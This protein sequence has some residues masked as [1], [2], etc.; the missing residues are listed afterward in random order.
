MPKNVF[1]R[2][3]AWKYPLAI[4]MLMFLL[5]N[6]AVLMRKRPD[7]AGVAH[8]DHAKLRDFFAHFHHRHEKLAQIETRSRNYDEIFSEINMY[9]FL[10]KNSF[11][12]RCMIYFNHLSMSNPDWMVNPDQGIV[13]NRDAYKSFD[14][15]REQALKDIE[16]KLNDAKEKGDNYVPPSDD[17]IRRKFDEMRETVL[18]DEQTLHDYLAHVRIFDKCFMG[19][20][21]TGSNKDDIAFVKKQR[22]F[23]KKSVVYLKSTADQVSGKL[24][25][26]ELDCND[27]ESKIFPW[28]TN[29]YPV[30]TRWN[31]RLTFFPGMSGRLPQKRGCFLSEYKSRLN[32]RGIVMT[33]KDDHVSD[34]SRFLRLLR[35]LGNQYPIQVVYHL[36]L[37]E[38]SRANLVRAARDY[39]RG[40]PE[41][42]LWF[43]NAER[44]IEGKYRGKFGGFANKIMATMFNSF[45]EML[46]CDA[47]SVLLESPLYFF[48]LKKFVDKGTVF[49]KD[50]AS[51][52]YRG[53][54]DLKFFRKLLPSVED[55]AIFNVAQPTDF[56]LNNEF[57]EGFSH[58]MESG[59]V[60]VDRTRHFIQPMMMS[61]LTFYHPVVAR[62]YGDKELFWLALSLAGDENYAFNNH[63]AAAIGEFTPVQER[64]KD[65]NSIQSFRLQE[66]CSNHPAHISDSDDQ[67]L[68]WF[69][70]G[71]RH[72]GNSLKKDMKWNDEFN[73]KTRYTKIKTLEEF[74]TFFKAPLK[75]KNAVIP[76][77]ERQEK[78]LKNVEHEP[79]KPWIMGHYCDNYLWCAYSLIG[80]YYVEDGETKDNLKQGLVITFSPE[81]VKR[82]E[83]A[84]DVWGAD[85]EWQ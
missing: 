34:A 26:H 31:G 58:Y 77:F 5:W 21:T 14:K 75:I 42:D 37:N 15:Y 32:G 80:G 76:P 67:T 8:L 7:F 13:F 78:L 43:V 57:F 84:G 4:A 33:L 62:V 25:K 2:M 35:Y 65:I 27:V 53:A 70:S 49:Y 39:F 18:N 46:L 66:L 40:Y 69:N 79:E 55:S 59:V 38:E 54:D 10:S 45:E 23:L 9:D 74:K 11:H 16:R 60:A 83:A 52:Q 71:F 17:E 24:F 19:S 20:A 72:C 73:K 29:Q 61:I 3:Y 47:D 64:H 50:R 41:Q 56:T 6:L 12:D 30:F 1:S 51:G 44:A 68:V 48:E 22:N 63:F 82:F 36:N 81:Q 28:F 85:F